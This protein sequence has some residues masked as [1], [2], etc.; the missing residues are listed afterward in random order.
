M[1]YINGNADGPD[2]GDASEAE[3][4]NLEQDNEEWNADSEFPFARVHSSNG[5]PS[6]AVV[7][8]SPGLSTE[9][10]HRNQKPLQPDQSLTLA[11]RELAVKEDYYKAKLNILEQRNTL[12]SNQNNQM[13][14]QQVLISQKNVILERIASTLE[15]LCER[16]LLN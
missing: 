10:R 6:S 4:S 16:G 2:D 3:L 9:R 7:R 11:E 8:N 1:V 12:L 13:R 14:E 15:K 5:H